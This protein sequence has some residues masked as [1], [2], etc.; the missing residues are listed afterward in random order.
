MHNIGKSTF[1]FHSFSLK[2]DDFTQLPSDTTGALDIWIVVVV[3]FYS[4]LMAFHIFFAEVGY[5]SVK[6]C[7]V[8]LPNCTHTVSTICKM[9]IR[10]FKKKT[11]SLI[12]C[13]PW[14]TAFKLVLDAQ[15]I[16]RAKQANFLSND[17]STWMPF[18]HE[19]V[20]HCFEGQL[21][22]AIFFRHKS[23]T[24]FLLY[25]CAPSYCNGSNTILTWRFYASGANGWY[26]ITLDRVQAA[27]PSSC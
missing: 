26:P 20:D 3:P 13:R 19:I 21:S 6:L 9:L 11:V 22:P 5:W 10:W 7:M 8:K 12:K 23:I 16:F 1:L 15:F 27:A 17:P 14:G 18:F 25:V 24:Y 4:S 2:C